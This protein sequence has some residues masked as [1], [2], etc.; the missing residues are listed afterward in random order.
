LIAGTGKQEK[1]IGTSNHFKEQAT[2]SAYD[3]NE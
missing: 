3:T 2:Q 1:R